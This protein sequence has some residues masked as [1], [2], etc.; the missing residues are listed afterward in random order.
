VR[1]YV[2]LYPQLIGA[3]IRAQMQYRASFLAELLGN[4]LITS[5]DFVTLAILLTQFQAIGGWTLPEVALLYGTS[6]VSFSLAEIL[7][8]ILDDFDRWIIRGEFD[9]L[10]I[11]PLG[12]MFQV[13]TGAFAL[14]RL[15]RLT[16]G[17]AALILAL[18]WLHPNWQIERWAFLG[19]TLISGFLFF[20]AI[21]IAGAT[22]SFWTPQ[23]AELANIFTYGGNFM[24]SYPMHIYE[25]WIRNIFTFLL[26]MAFINYYPALYL[27]GKPDPFGLPGWVPFL[28]PP[29][30]GGVFL[31]SLAVWRVGVRHYQ[32]TGS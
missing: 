16:Q 23:T 32:S 21:F 28:S 22:T 3:Q 13:M 30:A 1:E 17:V 12:M 20:M 7:G 14:R 11:R 31:A 10:L 15:G 27:L 9:R 26:P 19:V 4:F 24:T 5:L 18:W 2:R 6:T 8:G 25:E 29:I